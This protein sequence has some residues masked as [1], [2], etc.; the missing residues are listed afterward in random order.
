MRSSSSFIAYIDESGDEGFNFR[1]NGSG[2]TR[3]FVL[4]AVV[5]HHAF[6]RSCV[7]ALHG[8]RQLLGRDVEHPFHLQKMDHG[9]RL[10]LFHEL[11]K[12]RFRC[13]SV[14]CHKPDLPDI[15]TL[16]AH[17]YMLYRRLTGVL[18]QRLS[19]LGRD[20]VGHDGEDGTVDLVFSARSWMSYDDVRRDIQRL[21]QEAQ[22]R[23]DASTHWPAIRLDRL[24]AVQHEKLA[25]LQVAD[26][27]ASG[28]FYAVNPSRLGV[29][30]PSYL[31]LLKRNVYHQRG[32]WLNTGMTFMSDFASLKR[33]MPHL[34]AAFERW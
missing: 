25:G 16:R 20:H 32:R 10:L 18:V 31:R 7:S 30:D 5:F 8:V 29:A 4:S 3:W 24:K 11:A 21:R 28:M 17:K 15:A 19:W 34:G 14:L 27:V 13:V 9:S 22:D 2:S 23:G 1:A 6:E 33:R 26:A 12:L